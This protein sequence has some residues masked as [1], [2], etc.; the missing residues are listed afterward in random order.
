MSWLYVSL[1]I[2]GAE[3]TVRVI[4]VLYSGYFV[5][6]MFELCTPTSSGQSAYKIRIRYSQQW[7]VKAGSFIYVRILTTD[8]F[9][10][11]HPFTAYRSPTA[12]YGSKE[13][14]LVCKEKKG[15]TKK[16]A[17]RLRCSENYSIILPLLIDG[18]YG[19]TIPLSSYSSVLM[20][21]G[22][23]GFT[24]AYSYAS[25]FRRE[26]LPRKVLFIWVVR[27]EEMISWFQSELEQLSKNEI[28]DV[29]IF[30]TGKEQCGQNLASNSL[31]SSK[32]LTNLNSEE[33]LEVPDITT[34]SQTYYMRPSINT[35]ITS[36]ICSA[37]F[38]GVVFTCGPPR[39]VDEARYSV[40][41]NIEGSP[42][43]VDYFE[44]AFAW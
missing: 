43:S 16:I 23:I 14:Q 19:L 37:E 22:G 1:G 15:L 5:T 25:E 38:S 4:R 7:D 24:A 20:L 8:G 9:W 2:Y 40:V 3:R 13:L 10:Q 29:R 6:G 26:N 42:N 36:F 21:V 18:P 17:T 34:T 41:H 44:E 39:F 28:V 35:E 27:E 11:S 12:L 32:S 30:V 31:N 33:I